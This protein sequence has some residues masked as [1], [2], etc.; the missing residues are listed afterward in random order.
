ML[1]L[2]AI[3]ICSLGYE[4]EKLFEN[5]MFLNERKDF[6]LFV[7]A[8]KAPVG[9]V[10]DM[11]LLVNIIMCFLIIQRKN[12]IFEKLVECMVPGGRIEANSLIK[13]ASEFKLCLDKVIAKGDVGVK[14]LKLIIVFAGRLYF[15]LNNAVFAMKTLLVL[16]EE[17]T[18]SKKSAQINTYV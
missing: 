4:Q 1:S 15:H 5:L 2:Q 13:I 6:I 14:A 8:R 11:K 9:N 17:E 3:V 18:E 7:E 12:C 10:L 16:T